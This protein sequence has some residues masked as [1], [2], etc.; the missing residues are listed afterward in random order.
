MDAIP[1]GE[2]VLMGT[3]SLN[4]HQNVILFD[5]GAT[6]D[7][8]SKAYTQKYQLPIAHTHTPY[9]ISTPG[10]NIITQQVVLSIPLN[11]A[12]KLYKIS[13]IVLDGQ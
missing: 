1:E 10:G 4:G 2:Q 3:F 7:F 8:I 9:R 6:H 5:S 13:L 11:L 12:R